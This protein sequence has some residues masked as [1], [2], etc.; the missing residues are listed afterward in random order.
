[1][2]VWNLTTWLSCSDMHSITYLIEVPNV[3]LDPH[4]SIT[5]SLEESFVSVKIC[6]I[7]V[8][9]K[10]GELWTYHAVF[11]NVVQAPQRSFLPSPV[12][13]S[14]LKWTSLIWGARFQWLVSGCVSLRHVLSSL[15]G[16]TSLL[17]IYQDPSTGNI[18]ITQLST[19]LII[20]PRCIST[21]CTINGATHLSLT[22]SAPTT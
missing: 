10:L 15:S 6:S 22:T 12:H 16:Q 18:G 3:W 1:M 7:C 17:T 11:L 20:L 2:E 5:F 21:N 8:I 4:N 14:W 9:G 19:V 13:F